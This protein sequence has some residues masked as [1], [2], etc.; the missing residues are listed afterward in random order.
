MPWNNMWKRNQSMMAELAK[1]DFINRVIFINPFISVLRTFFLKD[2]R[3]KISAIIKTRLFSKKV[4]SKILVYTPNYILP[5]MKF[6]VGL[7]SFESKIVSKIMLKII[8]RL[9]HDMPYILFMNCPNIYFS[10][11]L[12][13]LLKN[14][15][16]S[17]FDF[18]DDFLELGYSLKSLKLFKR[19]IEI[20]ASAA[21][22][23]LTVNEHVKEK[24]SYLNANMHLIR[25]AT[26]FNNFDRKKFKSVSLL[27]R[28]K[29]KNS[30]IIGYCGIANTNRID[31]S[32]VD[33]LIKKRPN[34][35][36]VFIGTT[37]KELLEK[38]LKHQNFNHIPPVDYKNLPNYLDYFD[39]AIVP[40]KVNEH[41]KGNDLLKIHDFLA[42]GKAVVSTEIGGAADLKHVIK[43]ARNPSEFLEAIEN[44]LCNVSKE[45]ILKRKKCARKN[46]WP[47]RIA[48]FEYL[49]KNYLS[50]Y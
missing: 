24:Y 15:K 32:I 22:F 18:S 33:Y 23:V 39:V 4:T 13:E 12:D 2:G 47:E 8:E 34:W 20:F 9:N 25:N 50:I 36:F 3:Y 49:L 21:N 6:P 35:Q 48:E 16:L 44:E 1:C 40:F 11:I 7:A 29:I 30:P 41:T 31:T 19:N 38:Y 43:I 26:N 28:I 5:R 27:K 14:A 10:D 37:E 46:S 17:V 45:A 42:M